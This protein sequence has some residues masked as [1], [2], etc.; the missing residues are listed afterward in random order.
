MQ[1]RKGNTATLIGSKHLFVVRLASVGMLDNNLGGS[2]RAPK[3]G[4]GAKVIQVKRILQPD[5]LGNL[6]ANRYLPSVRRL[7][8]LEGFHQQKIRECQQETSLENASTP[9]T[10]R[11][12]HLRSA[13]HR[14]RVI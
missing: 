9:W 2:M 10:V 12:Y 3:I 5:K 1:E 11:S 13:L 14:S 7:F 6:M 8:G 4:T